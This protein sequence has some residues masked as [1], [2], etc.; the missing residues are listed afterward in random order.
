[1]KSMPLRQ[2]GVIRMSKWYDMSGKNDDVVVASRIRLARNF[3]DY[4][5][6]GMME[7]EDSEKL[8]QSVTEAFQ[9]DYRNEYNYCYTD[10]C[11]DIGKQSL[12]ERLIINE[13]LGGRTDGAAIISEDESAAILLNAEDHVRIQVIRSGMNM[14]ECYNVANEIDDYLDGRFDYAFDEKY[15][16]KTTYPTNIGTGLRASYILHLP[17]L[18]D[19]RKLSHISTELGRFGMKFKPVFTE[20]N[21]Q[22]GSF[23]R[24]STQRSIGL[25]E[26]E[27]IKD[28]DDMV[29]RL[30]NQ[31]REQREA[32]Y[33]TNRIQME[34]EVYKSYGVMKYARRL[35][36]KD[37]LMLI[38]VLK[39]GIALGILKF[40]DGTEYNTIKM[41]ME[42]MPS[43]IA[44]RAGGTLSS[45]ETE[46]ERATYIRDNAPEIV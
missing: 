9:T 28:L 23:Y 32:F 33:S 7:K 38:S 21:G 15:G 27:I 22:S 35:S 30:I 29:Y 24:I 20:G 8:I 4:V 41:I 36:F 6:S 46:I 11:G 18:R 31:E 17:S 14:A 26:K 16:Y 2:T 1:M 10:R 44:K 12:K 37:A 42:I 13:Y 3:K 5:Y 45:E 34:D 39:Q 40:R 43:V 25:S 19:A